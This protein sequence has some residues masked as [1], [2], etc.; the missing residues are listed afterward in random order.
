MLTPNKVPLVE[1]DT[2]ETTGKAMEVL[3]PDTESRVVPEVS[4]ALFDEPDVAPVVSG[5]KRG[6]P[7]S[8]KAVRPPMDARFKVKGPCTAE[9]WGFVRGWIE[10]HAG[11]FSE[12]DLCAVFNVAKTTLREHMEGDL[13]AYTLSDESR[14]GGKNGIDEEIAKKRLLAIEAILDG[15]ARASLRDIQEGLAVQGVEAGRSTIWKDLTDNGWRA[16]A[17]M[18]V[19]WAGQGGREMW[20]AKRLEFAEAFLEKREWTSDS[21]LFSDESIFR[22]TDDRKVQWCRVND[23]PD[24]REVHKWT[25]S[26]HCWACI[27]VGFKFITCIQDL[28][29]GP[30]GGVTSEDF[31]KFLKSK[32]EAKLNRH[33]MR[34]PTKRFLFVQDGAR[35]HT[36]PAS[37]E[38]IRGLG[39]AVLAKNVWPAHS[40]DL[41]PIENLWGISKRAISKEIW[42]DLS[43][44]KANTERLASAIDEFW[45]EHSVDDVNNLVTSFETRLKVVVRKKG[46]ETGY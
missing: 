4:R 14:S 5:R 12:R 39:V 45:A 11:I 29:T 26:L 21:L 34:H 16:K 17:R 43:A 38:Y 15:N 8:K 19:P 13:G 10:S 18:I 3:E 2:P 9:G 28:G 46:A 7:P 40:P 36:T 25:A 24:S 30:R 35:I 20:M 27:G 32:F 23:L 44:S 1:A 41:N 6:R 37:L 31:V 33:L 42:W 22:C